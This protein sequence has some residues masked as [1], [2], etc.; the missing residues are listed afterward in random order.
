MLEQ[1]PQ[2]LA[3]MRPPRVL[4]SVNRALGTEVA[5]SFMRHPS[6]PFGDSRDVPGLPPALLEFLRRDDHDIH[7]DPP[8]LRRTHE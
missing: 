2:S 3:Q 8:A 7:R 4:E 5:S 1:T 6:R